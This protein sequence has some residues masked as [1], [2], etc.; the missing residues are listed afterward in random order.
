MNDR[1]RFQAAQDA[2][3]DSFSAMIYGKGEPK[4]LPAV[5][6]LARCISEFQAMLKAAGHAPMIEGLML[7]V[8]VDR[9]FQACSIDIIDELRDA[10]HSEIDEH[11][12][13]SS[14]RH[15]RPVTKST[16]F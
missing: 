1:E 4:E 12:V 15:P 11:T 5:E 7:K 9:F 16:R 13:A 2:V 6:V 8:F 3:T 14:C 10:M